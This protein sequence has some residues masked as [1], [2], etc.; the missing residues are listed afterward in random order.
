MAE[1]NYDS[2]KVYD[3]VYTNNPNY[4]V[5]GRNKIRFVE[6]FCDSIDG[7]LLDVGCGAGDNLKRMIGNG[8]NAFGIE[9]SEVVCDIHLKNLPH[10]NIDAI[11][12]A[13]RCRERGEVY[14]GLICDDVL[15]HIPPTEIDN[16][17]E[18][19]TWMAPKQL[20]GIAN[21]PCPV[22]G[23]ELHLIQ[24]NCS[25]W[26]AKLEKHYKSVELIQRLN[27]ANKLG[28]GFYFFHVSP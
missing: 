7:I 13:N 10:E 12:F 25:W 1:T 16:F 21:H 19:L 28:H 14:D 6:S 4:N 18:A 8:K 2:R 26:T 15:E 22:D 27:E 24:E 5:Q 17:L 23:Y 9:I 11:T 3:L 20:L